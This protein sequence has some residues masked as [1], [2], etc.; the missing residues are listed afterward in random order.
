MLFNGMIAPLVHYGLK[1]AIWFQADG[2]LGDVDEY[3]TLIKALI[4]DWRAQWYRPL[5][6]YYVEMNNMR[7]YPQTK[8]VQYNPLCV[9]R[10]QQQAALD[11]PNT[12]VVCSIDVGLPLPE[13]H[14]PNKKP[15]GD[16][17]A[18]LAL[19]DVYGQ[20]GLVNSPAYK[21][22]DVEGN[23]IRLT[24]TSADGLRLMPGHPFAGFAIKG[25]T[26]DWVWAQGQIDGQTIVVWNDSVPKPVA[27]RYAW[28]A[29]P[30]V[31]IQNAAGLPLRPFR[32]DTDSPQ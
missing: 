13:P 29:N 18:A 28:A 10:E 16:R 31:S 17:L 21:S 7:D 27:V 9:L 6:F 3:G 5:P 8:P 26:G 20:K 11:L 30:I 1:G 19:N 22:F 32:T 25:A 12:G 15:V 24:F 2:N 4:S 14:F 23:K